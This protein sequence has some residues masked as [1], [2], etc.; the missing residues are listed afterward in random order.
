MKVKCDHLGYYQK[1][2]LVE[3][4]KLERGLE[5]SQSCCKENTEI[6]FRDCKM[7]RIPF[8]S[9]ILYHVPNLTCL[10][11]VESGVKRISQEDLAGFQC[12]KELNM[13]DNE[14]EFLPANLFHQAP[15]LEVISF[16]SNIIKYIQNQAIIDPLRA[17]KSF[18][19]RRNVNISAIYARDVKRAHFVSKAELKQ[20]IST[21]CAPP[22]RQKDIEAIEKQ[23]N[24]TLKWQER[25]EKL[26]EKHFEETMSYT[27]R[28]DELEEEVKTL[29]LEKKKFLND[30]VVKVNG[31]EFKVQKKMLI[32]NSPVLKA[33]IEK[34]PEAESLELKD[35]S[36]QTVEEILEFMN[37]EK[38]PNEATNLFEMHTACQRLQFKELSQLT[39]RLLKKKINPENA[40][41]ILSRC[42][43][44]FKIKAL[45]E[46]AKHNED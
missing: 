24:E 9:S 36:S 32:E 10:T 18:D 6:M 39:E 35:I 46:Y 12:L 23:R 21:N 7:Y 15:N 3:K 14:I 4:Q 34:D 5:F 25:Y 17:L 26:I 44:D 22:A 13:Q 2:C 16:A 1:Y 11:I 19:L 41:E 30:F 45:Q 29:K 31:K 42:G 8:A 40:W 20:L 33:L 28:I 37:D 27:T 38:L 43:D